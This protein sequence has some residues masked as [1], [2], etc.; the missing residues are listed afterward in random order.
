MS[1]R[2]LTLSDL[3][4]YYSTN[5][6]KSTHF[7]YK[8]YDSSPIV[9]QV[10]GNLKFEESDS[11][12]EGLLPV[13][14]QSCHIDKNL[15]GSNIKEDVMINALPSFKN[16][17]ILG[18]IHEVDGKPQFYGHN[19]HIDDEDNIVYD[20]IPVGIVPESCDAKLEYDEDKDKTY[21]VVNGYIFEEYTKAAE[22][23]KREKEC[24]VSVELCIRELSYNAKE[25]YLDIEDFYF[26]GVTILGVDEDGDDVNPGMAGSN[27]KLS[28]FSV[29]KNSNFSHTEI[30]EKLI[31]TLDK[32]NTTLSNFNKNKSKEGGQDMDKKFEELLEK[33]EKT[34]EDIDFDYQEMSEE[35]LEAKFEEL[36]GED[37]SSDDE[38][39]D[40]GEESADG[41]DEGDSGEDPDDDGDESGNDES[42]NDE[43][44]SDQQFSNKFSVEFNGKIRTFELSLDEKIY[45]L[46]DLVNTTYGES[47]NAWYSV[48]VYES[49]LIMVDW[50]TGVAYKQ[51]YTQD[52]DNFTLTGDRVEVYAN[53]LTKEE[54]DA[55][56]EMRSNYSVIKSE[57]DT[58]K[59]AESDAKKEEIFSDES[60]ANYLE[61]DEFKSLIENKDKYSV[62]ELKEKAELAFAKCVKK[63]GSFSLGETTKQTKKHGLFSTKNT[64]EKKPYGN[65]FD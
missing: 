27:I 34:K 56:D 64:E 30:N 12:K 23:L 4:S 55:L 39:S 50:W 22:I 59:K 62:E 21:C 53:W 29:E 58:Y 1:N 36:F 20:E 13:V 51:S 8:N 47:D 63:N 26:S 42:G 33:Y 15:N 65:L 32:L 52:G 41:A 7:S 38:S 28:D 54:E 57:L 24:A 2:L 35:D 43:S 17:P 19:M 44:D 18:Y 48:K 31:E 40:S 61:T 5:F 46:S 45:A 60:Y 16:R 9:V 3:Y 49:Y 10:H 25:K 37:T 14:L 6:K 11:D